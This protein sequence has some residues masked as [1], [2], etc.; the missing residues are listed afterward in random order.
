MHYNCAPPEAVLED[1]MKSGLDAVAQYNREQEFEAADGGDY[2]DAD[3]EYLVETALQ[4]KDMA[5]YEAAFSETPEIARVWA[6]AAAD[7]CTWGEARKN[8][9]YLINTA[10]SNDAFYIANMLERA[11]FVLQDGTKAPMLAVDGAGD[12]ARRLSID[13]EEPK[14]IVTER[15]FDAENLRFMLQDDNGRRG[16]LYGKN[17]VLY[18]P[19]DPLRPMTDEERRSRKEIRKRVKRMTGKQYCRQCGELRGGLMSG[20]LCPSCKGSETAGSR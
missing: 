5:E 3:E 12:L 15:T 7:A 13:H 4:T 10:L 19:K 20:G 17:E 2:A 6:E 8:F 9:W 18:L 14:S 1:F 11:G 16:T